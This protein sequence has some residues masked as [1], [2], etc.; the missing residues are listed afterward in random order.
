MLAAGVEGIAAALRPA[1]RHL[2]ARLDLSQR[3]VGARAFIERHHDIGA[4]QAPD[5]H[6]AFGGEHMLAAVEMA[7]E[8]DPFLGQLVEVRQAH[9]LIAAAVRQDRAIPV[10]E[11]VQPAKA[12]NPLR[13]RPQHEVVGIAEDDVRARAAHVLRFH[14]FHGGSGADRHE[15][16]RA[17]LA[18]THGDR[19]GARGAAGG[20][21]G[22]LET[23]AHR[24]P[25]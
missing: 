15:G 22:E 12:R 8:F 3:P 21:D 1:H 4:E 5:F 9:H 16:G 25:S 20:G 7:A 17:D 23:C 2:H 10:H 6:A 24:L 14:A 19:A 13:P 11:F 18:A